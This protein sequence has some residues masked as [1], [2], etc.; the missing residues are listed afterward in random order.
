ME[1]LRQQ[2]I[3]TERRIHDLLDK[4]NEGAAGR[5]ISEI[6]LL[7]SD[8]QTGKNIYS[9]EDRVKRIINILGGEA[10]NAQIMDYGHLDMFKAWFQNLLQTFQ[11]MS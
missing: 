5:L 4:P 7:E 10:R 9:M 11:K 1:P 3:A 6:R 2:L 8:L